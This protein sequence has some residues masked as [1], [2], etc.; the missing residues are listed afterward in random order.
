MNPPQQVVT[1]AVTWNTTLPDFTSGA[2]VNQYIIA[3]LQSYTNNILVGQ[4]INLLVATQL[5]QEAVTPVLNPINLTTLGFVV[6][7][8]AEVVEPTAGT[9][10]IPSDVESYFFCSPT[11]VTSE[12]G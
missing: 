9:S 10:I 8:N 4:P 12:Q 2:A 3:A 11:G 5:I 1:W 7:I 6:T